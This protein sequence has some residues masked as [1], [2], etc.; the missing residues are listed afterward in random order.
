MA[1][2]KI[3]HSIVKGTLAEILAVT[4]DYIGQRA[5]SS[6]YGV[7]LGL[8]WYWNGTTWKLTAGKQLA[9]TFRAATGYTVP[10]DANVNTL[11]TYTLPALGGADSMIVEMFWTLNNN[12]NAK[13]AVVSM[14]GSSGVSTDLASAVS[15]NMITV[16]RNMGGLTYT[17]S[18]YSNNKVVFGT[19]TGSLQTTSSAAA[20]ARDTG[21]AGKVVLIT[22]QKATAGDTMV[23]NYADIYLQGGGV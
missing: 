12:A 3:M 5:I 9:A 22:G 21:V 15:S 6:D 8:E 19:S 2:T 4:G 16:M 11:V 1:A 18:W 17:Q 20:G 13:T 10:A 7:G 23:L 14:G